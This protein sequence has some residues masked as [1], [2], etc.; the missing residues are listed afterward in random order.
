MIPNCPVVLGDKPQGSMSR[1]EKKMFTPQ[2]LQKSIVGPRTLGSHPSSLLKNPT[3]Y[4][5]LG[6]RPCVS[7]G[8]QDSVVSLEQGLDNS[9]D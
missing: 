8:R 5:D 2:G 6:N 7:S 4:S 9:Q 1:E 3:P